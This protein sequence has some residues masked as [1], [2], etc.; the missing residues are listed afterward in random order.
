MRGRAVRELVVL[1]HDEAGDEGEQA[2]GVEQGV[3]D[4]AG[5]LLFRGMGGLQDE[6]A[7]RDEQEA[8][9][10]EELGSWVS[11]RNVR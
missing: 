3:D 5:L 6:D 11:G 2:G 10:V 7:L 8:G 1:D 9:G 4:G